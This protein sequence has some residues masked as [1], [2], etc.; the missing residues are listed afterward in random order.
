MSYTLSYTLTV[1]ER[2]VGI[3]GNALSQRPYHEV[4]EIISR[5]NVQ[6]TEQTKASDDPPPQPR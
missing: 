5:L 3:I 6:L 4:F 2:D 1:S